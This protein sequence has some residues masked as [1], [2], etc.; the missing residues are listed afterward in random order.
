MPLPEGL[1]NT[2]SDPQ[3]NDRL[4]DALVRV[5]PRYIQEKF[6]HYAPIYS[7]TWELLQKKGAVK[8][9]IPPGVWKV[10]LNP[11][12]RTPV[13]V[14]SDVYS[15]YTNFG[16]G[17][18]TDFRGIADLT[19]LQLFFQNTFEPAK[20]KIE[21]AIDSYSL[22][23]RLEGSFL[24]DY[25]ES[26]LDRAIQGHIYDLNAR[27]WN[28]GNIGSLSGTTGNKE[29]KLTMTDQV[30]SIPN[31]V[32]S[33]VFG[34]IRKDATNNRNDVLALVTADD[35]YGFNAT[36]YD[37]VV[38]KLRFFRNG[39]GSHTG[40]SDLLD[41]PTVSYLGAYKRGHPPKTTEKNY[42]PT[43][44]A[45]IYTTYQRG[46]W[47]QVPSRLQ[48]YS[49]TT[50]KLAT[51]RLVDQ[52][53]SGVRIKNKSEINKRPMGTDGSEAHV[54]HQDHVSLVPLNV[55]DLNL[56]LSNH[57]STN[58]RMP[59]VCI[60]HP[61]VLTWMINEMWAVRNIIDSF[62]GAFGNVNITSVRGVPIFTDERVEPNVLNDALDGKPA[63]TRLYHV[64]F[65]SFNPTAMHFRL[66][67][68]GKDLQHF[69]MPVPAEYWVGWYYL[70]L[71]AADML[72]HSFM[73]NY[74]LSANGS[75]AF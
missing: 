19:R 9:D 2:F 52:V 5:V 70:Q 45:D 67:M 72:Q 11:V 73:T 60:T 12:I 30:F 43:N 28:F 51:P 75:S 49:N 14:K 46:W 66:S 23:V 20:M 63:G 38:Q 6:I 65:L 62:T 29:E 25:V 53:F 74:Y 24:R 47:Y 36:D 21:A 39:A 7:K 31:A 59:D 33:C 40:V 22:E 13:E 15:T 42:G 71:I 16:P 1:S 4:R 69:K 26:I 37:S 56:I 61:V 48:H 68:K 18:K 8:S 35:L 64:Y 34:I 27:L 54:I 41:A 3:F 44:E 10:A 57:E 17:D 58:N 55:S 32:N 50:F